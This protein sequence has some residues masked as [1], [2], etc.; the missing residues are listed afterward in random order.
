MCS[1]RPDR[2]CRCSRAS[3][4]PAAADRDRSRGHRVFHDGARGGRAGAAGLG[5]AAG[6][7]RRRRRRGKIFVLDMGEPVKIVD[8][9]RQMI[10]LAGLR[11]DKRHRDRLYRAAA[12]REAARGVVSRGRITDADATTRLCASPPRA[13]PIMRC[14]R[15][16]S[17]SSKRTPGSAARSGVCR[18][19]S[20]WSPNT[21]VTP[22]PPSAAAIAGR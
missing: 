10:R 9:A 1:A 14:W 12:R 2:W 21:A 6:G 22:S 17:T 11:P 19:S 16:R 7:A 4:P 18:S 8:L 13:P 20:G 5:V 3:S 15:A